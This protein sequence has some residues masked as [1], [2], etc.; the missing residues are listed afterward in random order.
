MPVV[1]GQRLWITGR[2]GLV[3]TVSAEQP[4]QGR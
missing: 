4:P 2:R 1:A 3:L